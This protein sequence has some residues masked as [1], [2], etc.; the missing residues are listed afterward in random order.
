MTTRSDEA[1]TQ[2]NDHRVLVV[3]RVFAA[4]SEPEHEAMDGAPRLP[5][6]ASGG[7]NPPVTTLAGIAVSISWP[8]IFS[9]FETVAFRHS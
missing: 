9:P 2:A 4:W 7:R 5:R 6:R 1:A 3:T 8:S